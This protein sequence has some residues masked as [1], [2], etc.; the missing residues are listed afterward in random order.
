M[1]TSPIEL[2][3]TATAN[4]LRNY[5]VDAN[6]CW[7][8]TIC[9]QGTKGN[10]YPA[11]RWMIQGVLFQARAHR[12][13]YTLHVGPIPDELAI[14]HTCNNK[15]CINPE[16]LEAVTQEEN[17]RRKGARLTHCKHGHERT[18]DNLTPRGGC[19]TCQREYMK[20]YKRLR[21]HDTRNDLPRYLRDQRKV[22]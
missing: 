15:T 10:K 9:M 16:H 19:K 13:S 11:V 5:T 3:P 17:N 7:N 6:G 2:H 14:D 1:K 21:K 22:H 18:T 12:Y 8:R 20:T 4:L